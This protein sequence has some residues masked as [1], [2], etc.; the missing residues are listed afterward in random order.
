[1]AG[2]ALALAGLIVLL[3][4]VQASPGEIIGP[5]GLVPPVACGNAFT[6]PRLTGILTDID[7][8]TGGPGMFQQM[9]D[10][11]CSDAKTPRRITGWLLV[12]A[13]LL[14]LLYLAVLTAARRARPPV[15]PAED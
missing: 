2:C 12:A 4:Q 3:G 11:A 1:V 14:A 9:A 15:E 13:G 7:A 6:G 8:D 5:D 10:T